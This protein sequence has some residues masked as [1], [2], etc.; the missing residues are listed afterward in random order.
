VPDGSLTL[1]GE[2][3]FEERSMAANIIALNVWQA[4]SRA[5]FFLLDREKQCD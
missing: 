1:S 3:K 2:R 4:R 5:P